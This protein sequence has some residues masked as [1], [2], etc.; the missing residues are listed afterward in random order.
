MERVDFDATGT[1]VVGISKE[2]TAYIWDTETGYQLW[3]LDA[4]GVPIKAITACGQR[5]VFLT[6]AADGTISARRPSNPPPSQRLPL[7]DAVQAQFNAQGDRVATLSQ[8]QELVFWDV[9]L[10]ATDA[11]GFGVTANP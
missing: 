4:R 5:G 1:K 9:T 6:S 11:P 8:T 10:P 2:G 3:K 7:G